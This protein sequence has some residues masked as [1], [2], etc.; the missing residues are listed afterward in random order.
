MTLSEPLHCNSISQRSLRLTEIPT[1]IPYLFKNMV[2]VRVLDC[3]LQ[4]DKRSDSYAV[5]YGPVCHSKPSAPQ[6]E[7]TKSMPH[8]GRSSQGGEQPKGAGG[9]GG[10]GGR[11]RGR[12]TFAKEGHSENPGHMVNTVSTK[13]SLGRVT[14]L[15]E[16]VGAPCCSG[17]C[18]KT[19]LTFVASK[20]NLPRPVADVS[21]R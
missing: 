21:R 15:G 13:K 12:L 11:G 20:L 19:I 9:W 3:L 4:H 5:L 14:C 10:G 16:G 8:I 2:R 18:L 17:A 6:K 7:K 1:L